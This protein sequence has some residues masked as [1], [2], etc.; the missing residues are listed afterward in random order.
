MPPDCLMLLLQVRGEQ[1]FD[2]R[3]WEHQELCAD[4]MLATLKV[5]MMFSYLHRCCIFSHGVT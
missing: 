1:A 4:W 2:V 5:R 3:Y